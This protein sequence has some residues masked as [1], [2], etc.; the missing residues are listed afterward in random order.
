MGQLIDAVRAAAIKE[1]YQDET[2]GW[3]RVFCFPDDFAGFAGHFPGAPVL[4]A[5]AQ[6]LAA[7]VVAETAIG[8]PL[9]LYSVTRAKFHVQILPGDP[10]TVS[11]KGGKAQASGNTMNAKIVVGDQL[12]ASFSMYFTDEEEE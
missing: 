9:R 3:T 11:C 8:K 1:L 4:P 12:A 10:V 2:N 6:V 5:I 7:Q